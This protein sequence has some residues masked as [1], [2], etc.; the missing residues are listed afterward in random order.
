MNNSSSINIQTGTRPDDGATVGVIKSD[1]M[2]LG[3][4]IA[5][6]D[7]QINVFSSQGDVIASV[8]DGSPEKTVR[9]TPY[10]DQDVMIAALEE[11]VEHW[12]E[13]KTF[14]SSSQEGLELLGRILLEER[15]RNRAAAEIRKDFQEEEASSEEHQ[16]PKQVP[17][18]GKLGPED[19]SAHWPRLGGMAARKETT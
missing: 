13:P 11:A 10:F 4:F 18:T 15:R 2:R 5:P 8:Y 16:Q 14:V 3:S 1:G 19:D 7:L 6:N 9:V 17:S 12:G